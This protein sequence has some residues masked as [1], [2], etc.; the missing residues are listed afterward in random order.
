MPDSSLHWLGPF[1][2]PLNPCGP[3]SASPLLCGSHHNP[4]KQA[5]H[6][7]CRN[8][9]LR[10]RLPPGLMV[11][12]WGCRGGSRA[13]GGHPAGDPCRQEL[14]LQGRGCLHSG[15]APRR[16]PPPGWKT[17]KPHPAGPGPWDK[18]MHLLSK[19]FVTP[20]LWSCAGQWR[21]DDP[22]Y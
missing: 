1:P 16:H 10:L 14:Y 4:T 11:S 9:K 2:L 6:P 7:H 5:D 17:R 8:E 21:H 22:S 20:T 19:G 15:S 13:E 18:E 3:C 12:L